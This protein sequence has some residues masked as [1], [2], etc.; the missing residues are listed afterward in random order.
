MLKK[1]HGDPVEK[2]FN[3]PMLFLGLFLLF[4]G[5]AVI[6]GRIFELSVPWAEE[7]LRNAFVVLLFWGAAFESKRGLVAITI[8]DDILLK[9]DRIGGY[10]VLQIVQKSLFLLF[11]FM[12]FYYTLEQMSGQIKSGVSSLTLGY[13]TWIFTAFILLGFFMMMM[14]QVILL[15]KTVSTP[16]EKLFAEA[17]AKHF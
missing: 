11:A 14:Y 16:R 3:Y 1:N 12:S 15:I 9:K 17:K 7:L 6:F 13:P 8:V 5:N 2:I 4:A 10:K